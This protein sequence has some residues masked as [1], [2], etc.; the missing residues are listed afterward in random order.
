MTSILPDKTKQITLS[1]GLVITLISGAYAAGAHS[2]SDPQ[3]QVKQAQEVQD[4]KVTLA[5][6]STILESMRER[7]DVITDDISDIQVRSHEMDTRVRVIS[8]DLER[9]K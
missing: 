9:R 3:A 2:P 4:I 6:V 5:K 7:Q 1:V 8:W